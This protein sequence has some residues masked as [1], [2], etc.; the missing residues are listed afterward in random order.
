MQYFSRKL[1]LFTRLLKSLITQKV[2]VFFRLRF[3]IDPFHPKSNVD[4]L[5]ESDIVPPN[6][7]LRQFHH[8]RHTVPKI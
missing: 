2:W 5:N 1:Q 3:I 7:T 4:N 6:A 8:S